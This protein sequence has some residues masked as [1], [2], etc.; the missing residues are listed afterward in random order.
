MCN[1]HCY[2]IMHITKF[3]LFIDLVLY[4]KENVSKFRSKF[5]I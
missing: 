1:K 3:Y 2:N 4:D 5:E